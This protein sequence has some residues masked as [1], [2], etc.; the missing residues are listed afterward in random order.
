[1]ALGGHIGVHHMMY[2]VSNEVDKEVS[3][4]EDITLSDTG[5]CD[6]LNPLEH[7][8]YGITALLPFNTIIK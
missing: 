4:Y 5:S 2:P 1:M 8:N 3:R 6:S 7:H